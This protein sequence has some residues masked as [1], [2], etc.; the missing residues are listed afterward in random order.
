[1]ASPL[2]PK[3]RPKIADLFC[4]AGGM[5]LGFEQAGFHI[6][7][8]VEADGHHVAA[9]HRNFPYSKTVCTSVTNIDAKKVREL[10][11]GSDIDVIIG[12]PPCQGFSNMG[13]RD[14]S[15]A[16][17][18]LIGEFARI[19]LDV[20]PKAFV[21]EN[22]PA[23]L[24]GGTRPLL[25]RVV[26]LFEA[27]GYTITK[28]LRVLTAS[29]FGVPQARSRLFVLGLRAD[30]PGRIE[31]P[32]GP[33]AGQP[34]R[35]T[36]MEA[37]ADLPAIESSDRLFKLDHT[38]YDRE[39][40]NIYSKVARSIEVDPSDLSYP[41]IWDTTSCSGCLRT[42]HSDASVALYRATPPGVM[43]PG[44]KLP[45]LDPNG[46][47][48][49]LR[50]G[51][52][53]TRGSY[54]AP[55]PIHPLLPRCI[56]TREAARLHGYPDWFMFFPTKWHAYKQV[57]NSVCPPVARAVGRQVMKALGVGSTRTVPARIQLTDEFELPEDR[58]KQHK[59]IPQ[60]GEYP[61][62]IAHLFESRFDK[63]R[64]ELKEARFTFADVQAAIAATGV[65]L[66][67]T[68]ADTFLSEVARSR[69]VKRFLS[70]P[71][72]QGYSIR[73]AEES[74]WIGEFVPADTIG[75]IDK[76][77]PWNIR[78]EEL[79]NALEI[80]MPVRHLNQ[81]A[82]EI[83]ALLDD[84]LVRSEIWP[85]EVVGIEA[86][87]GK[88]KPSASVR[89]IHTLRKGGKFDTCAVLLC[90]SENV[91]EIG[92]IERLAARELIAEVVSV[93]PLTGKHLLVARYSR[94]GKTMQEVARRVFVSDEAEPAQQQILLFA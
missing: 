61:P 76:R 39:A 31:Y 6:A 18:T 13:H 56:T 75:V 21:M 79:T 20:R 5:S 69:N 82:F 47:A 25:D 24:A 33:C 53:S 92:R 16:R 54:T 90:G 64:R 83:D 29:D 89:Y 8:G 49:T 66:S 93:T 78:I 2:Y 85:N 68:R 37:I 35:P 55:R 70:V 1:M 86:A 77:G 67:W 36:V 11:G 38:K 63:V 71:L 9:H 41:R 27:G 72:S 87:V 84:R 74:P 52:D 7:V 10:A 12:G 28:P 23:I 91:P 51:S 42:D 43:V 58:P 45:R 14:V 19:V 48:P 4:G 88:S 62:V 94:I 44:H 34:A 17:N 30:I 57:G 15:D 81:L 73:R 60:M 26:E 65:D 32:D 59:R 80:S 22:V 50:A 3:M 40:E 46:L